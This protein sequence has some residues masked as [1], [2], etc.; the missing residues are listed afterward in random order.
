MPSIF[1]SQSEQRGIGR[2]EVAESRLDAPLLAIF[3]IVCTIGLFIFHI[4]F[5]N[6]SYTLALT[7]SMAVFGTTIVKVEYGLY[8]LIIAMLLSPEIYAGSVGDH[9]ERGVN[10]R[11]D[12]ILIVI[13]FLG[14]IVKQAFENRLMVWRPNPINLGIVW[15]YCVCIISTLIALR[16][17]VPAW[18]KSVAFFVMLKMLE[19]YI[20]FFMVGV[21][22]TNAKI[23]RHQLTLFFAVSLIVCAYAI[24]TIGSSSRVSAPFEAGGTEPNTLGGYLL[25]VITIAGG[26]YCFAPKLKYKLMFFAIAATAF[27]PFLMTLSRAS[28][29]SLLVSLLILGVV[30]RK[31]SI[32]ALVAVVLIL[33]PFVMPQNVKDRIQYTFKESGVPVEIAGV[34]TTI[35]KSTYERIYIWEKVRFNLGVWPLFGGGVSWDT[36]LDS[37]YARVLI[38]TGIMGF[39]A[40]AYLLFMMLKTARESYRWNRYWVF[41]GLALGM[42]ATTAG[43][44]V[45]GLGTI[46]FLIVRI[47]EPFW[48][49]MALTVVAREIALVDY[50]QRLETYQRSQLADKDKVIPQAISPESTPNPA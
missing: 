29:T 7:V 17:D 12:D 22:V 19:F 49:L 1:S 28:Y 27:T 18:D 26:L 11:Y 31:Y 6:S 39:I 36:V 13:I 34:E 40:Y 16:Y 5:Q 45:H 15:Y 47:M 50:H 23:I 46:S 44:M 10:L 2:G 33:S 38:E 8:I 9:D 41:K 42:F 35:D 25:I 3:M 4:T 32:I 37:Q 20:I 21:V 48:F 30:A 43:L 14:I 24:S